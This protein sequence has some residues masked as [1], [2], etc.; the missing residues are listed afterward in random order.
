[1]NDPG[2][3]RFVYVT[4]PVDFDV[5]DLGG[6]AVTQGLCACVNVWTGRSVYLW[7]GKVQDDAEQ[8]ALFK[9]TLARENALREFIE[10]AHPCSVPC[11]AGLGPDLN[12][13]FA[14]FVRSAVSDP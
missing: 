8:F 13:A 11:L 1:M 3:I 14:G 2:A 9:T 6:R 7:E 5:S 10:Q 4:F 12:P